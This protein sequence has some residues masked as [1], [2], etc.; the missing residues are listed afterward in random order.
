MTLTVSMWSCF[1]TW[2]AGGFSV[3]DFAQT[4][5]EAGADGVELL[6]VFYKDPS[7]PWAPLTDENIA[8]GRKA[9]EKALGA[10]GLPCPIFSVTNDFAHL[11]DA[12]RIAALDSIRLGI[13]EANRYGAGIVR[14]FAGDVKEGVTFEQARAW[15]VEGLAAASKEAADNGVKLAL[16]NHGTLAGRADQV[17]A[18]IA[19]VR[20][21]AGNDALGANPDT[22]NFLVVDANAPESVASLADLASMVHFKDMV[23]TGEGEDPAFKSLG[24][25]GLKGCAIGEGDVELGACVKAL[26]AHGFDGPVSIEYE[27]SED[28]RT[29]VPRSIAATR[30]LIA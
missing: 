30:A 12:K 14:V 5:K 18:L 25:V 24:G 19:D 10:T 29:A 8:A 9:A 17:R 16:E 7:S 26:K 21:K 2:K 11:D 23:R 3:T 13:T 28:P 20:A 22:G 4:V 27:G 1:Q 15:I 6:D